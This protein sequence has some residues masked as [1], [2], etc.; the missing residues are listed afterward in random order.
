MTQRQSRWLLR[1]APYHR[2]TRTG[3]P[4]IDEAP[5]KSA[6]EECRPRRERG[7]TLAVG[8]Q[9]L[10]HPA[11][12]GLLVS[13]RR[14]GRTGTR[15]CIM[16]FN[17]PSSFPI[18]YAIAIF[19]YVN[20]GLFECCAI[21]NPQE[22]HD[23]SPR[24][25]II[26]EG[27]SFHGIDRVELSGHN[28]KENFRCQIHK[29]NK[30]NS[31]LPLCN[32]IS[33]LKAK[34]PDLYSFFLHIWRNRDPQPIVLGQT[35]SLKG[36]EIEIK[37]ISNFSINQPCMSSSKYGHIASSLELFSIEVV[38]WA[39]P[40]L[41]LERIWEPK[42]D[43]TPLY[44]IKNAGK[45]TWHGVA[46]LGHFYGRIEVFDKQSWRPYHRGG[47]CG[48]DLGGPNLNPHSQTVSSEG[49]FLDTPARFLPGKYRYML[50]ISTE[51]F[52]PYIL[53][54]YL[55]V[56]APNLQSKNIYWLVDEFVIK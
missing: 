5:A 17:M 2:H 44:Y 56:G 30:A 54:D 47:L 19:I 31:K 27:A 43:G 38:R 21:A 1:G 8:M 34:T 20:T 49:S 3:K 4:T 12:R 23:A 7:Q 42:A 15:W 13:V 53:C 45:Q 35:V 26:L 46:N 16:P 10:V 24:L 11:R 18:L 36:D 39:P 33:R 55:D 52:G 50:A 32:T 51:P 48:T 25:S 41:V 37:V 29:H 40:D 9:P 6:S 28:G 22:G 14:R